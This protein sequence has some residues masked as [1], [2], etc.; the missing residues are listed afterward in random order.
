MTCTG[1]QK[2]FD[3]YWDDETTQAERECLLQNQTS[4]EAVGAVEH[5][6]IPLRDVSVVDAHEC[7]GSSAGVFD[8]SSTASSSASSPRM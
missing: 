1:I 5:P 7:Y 8:R 6:A 4:G 2:L 3:A